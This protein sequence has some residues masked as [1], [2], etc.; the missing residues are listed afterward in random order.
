MYNNNNHFNGN[1]IDYAFYF[2]SFIIF[3]IHIF[4]SYIFNKK[5]IILKLTKISGVASHD[6]KHHESITEPSTVHL[7]REAL[8]FSPCLLGLIEVKLVSV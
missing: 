5:D 8:R 3:Y 7:S 4:I 6:K 2:Y 1:Y